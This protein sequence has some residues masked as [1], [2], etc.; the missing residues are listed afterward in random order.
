MGKMKVTV[1]SRSGREV[2]KGGIVINESVSA[3][4]AHFSSPRAIFRG[5]FSSCPVL[6]LFFFF[7]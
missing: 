6:S 3:R 1:V 2:V 5:F 7:F 4:P